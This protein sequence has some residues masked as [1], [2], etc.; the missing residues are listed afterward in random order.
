MLMK[1]GPKVS[2]HPGGEGD[3]HCCK[4][5][6]TYTETHMIVNVCEHVCVC[7]CVCVCVGGGGGGGGGRGE[8]GRNELERGRVTLI[9][10]Y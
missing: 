5:C 10:W 9:S 4:P 8:V 2:T 7:V 6:L 3:I 1:Q